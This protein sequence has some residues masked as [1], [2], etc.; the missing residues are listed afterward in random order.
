LNEN[1]DPITG[2]YASGNEMQSIMGNA[3][4][5]P[6]ITIGPGVTFGYIAAE[7]AL[8]SIKNL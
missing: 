5:A 4:P 7:H 3:Y 2:L 6:G 8:K 1:S